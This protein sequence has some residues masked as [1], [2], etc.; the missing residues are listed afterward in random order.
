[1][2]KQLGAVG[3]QLSFGGELILCRQVF[4]GGALWNAGGH[5]CGQDS[6]MINLGVN[7]KNQGGFDN[8]RVIS[9]AELQGVNDRLLKGI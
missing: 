8:R 2:W 4:G 1:M 5:S 7:L 9:F 3:A 6:S